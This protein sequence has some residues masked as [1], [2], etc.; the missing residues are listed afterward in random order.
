MPPSDNDKGGKYIQSLKPDND[1]RASLNFRVP[2][3]LRKQFNLAATARGE[4]MVDAAIR[5]FENY[6]EEAKKD[7]L[8]RR[9]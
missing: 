6:I 7:G 8:I 1:R 4:T 5:M 2:A 3:E 9:S